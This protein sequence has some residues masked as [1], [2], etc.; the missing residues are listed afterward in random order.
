MANT[1]D[2]SKKRNIKLEID[3]IENSIIPLFMHDIVELEK[4]LANLTGKEPRNFNF[5]HYVHVHAPT[6]FRA[7][8]Q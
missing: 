5:I 7:L 8:P 3:K 6:D 4:I 1:T 2:E